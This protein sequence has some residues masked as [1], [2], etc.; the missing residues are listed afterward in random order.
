MKAEE[1]ASVAQAVTKGMN[2]T[3]D[4]A[5]SADVLEE[6]TSGTSSS[7]EP[8]AASR[9]AGP[10]VGLVDVRDETN[11]AKSQEVASLKAEEDATVASKSKPQEETKLKAYEVAAVPEAGRTAMNFA[12]S[13][14]PVANV[15]KKA[16]RASK[17][18]PVPPPPPPPRH[19]PTQAAQQ[20]GGFF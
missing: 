20:S 9:E 4:P 3:E 12:E 16:R 10:Q 15:L 19:K 13:P 14:E 17:P 6:A 1:E 18:M 7:S 5:P 8:K 2:G 11:T